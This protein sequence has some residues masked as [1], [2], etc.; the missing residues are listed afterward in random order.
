MTLVHVTSLQKGVGE[1]A[2]TED[3][4]V[5]EVLGSWEIDVDTGFG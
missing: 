3:T 4:E 1:G 5:T 2:R